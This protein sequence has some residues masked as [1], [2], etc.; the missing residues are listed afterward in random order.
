MKRIAAA[1]LAV[2]MV[3]SVPMP[4]FAADSTPSAVT[5]EAKALESVIKS[6]KSRVSIPSDLD[7]FKY[8]TDTKYGVT[9]Y[10]L[11]W[12]K[13]RTVKYSWGTDTETVKS[14]TVRCHKDII[15]YV[16]VRDNE[17][18]DRTGFAKLTDTQ[19]ESR[20]A[21]YTPVLKAS[22]CLNV[23]GQRAPC[24]PRTSHTIS[25]DP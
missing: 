2:L 20:A 14:V 6:V 17:R 13:E 21:R 5:V 23:C 9:Y 15:I 18:K 7:K 1:L 24:V 3:G 11:T 4:V 19:A 12:Y 8:D 16:N 10:S 22:P 25:Q